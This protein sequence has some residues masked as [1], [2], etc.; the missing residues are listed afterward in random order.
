[1]ESKDGKAGAPICRKIA[2]AGFRIEADWFQQHGFALSLSEAPENRA[3]ASNK[4]PG[5]TSFFH[6]SNRLIE[7]LLCLG[8]PIELLALAVRTRGHDADDGVRETVADA[9]VR[10]LAAAKAFKPVGHMG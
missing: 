5:C 3:G 1:M 6:L 10:R 7:D 9:G 8:V 2:C 4:H